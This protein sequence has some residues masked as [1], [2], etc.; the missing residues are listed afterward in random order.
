MNRSKITIVRFLLLLL[1]SVAFLPRAV[2]SLADYVTTLVGEDPSNDANPASVDILSVYL[3]NNGTHFRFIIE[4]RATLA[5]SSIRSYTVWLDTKGGSASDYCLVAGGNSGL[6]KIQKKGR[7]MELNF[8]AP[9]EVV[10]EG[11]SIYLTANLSDI[12]YPEGVKKKV[13]IVVTTQ[14]PLDKVRDR[15]PDKGMY[16]VSHEVISELPGISSFIFTS[17]IIVAVYLIYRYKFKPM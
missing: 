7:S 17:S 9:I 6:Y 14:Q 5:P 16:K 10:V 8:K 15:A 3:A 12:E 4:C 2:V 13:G 11:N 1:I